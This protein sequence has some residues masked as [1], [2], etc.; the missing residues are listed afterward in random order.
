VRADA[1]SGTRLD[2]ENSMSP[3]FHTTL[4]PLFI[5]P[6]AL[7]IGCASGLPAVISSSPD[8]VAVEFDK[9]GSVKDTAKMAQAECA[10]VGKSAE[11]DSVDTSASPKT[12]IAEYKCVGGKADEADKADKAEGE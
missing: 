9:D 1:F 12:R 10:K 2:R 7:A 11:F 5:A 3:R 8:K 4:R 6:L